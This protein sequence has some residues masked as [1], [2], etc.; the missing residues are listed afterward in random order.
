MSYFFSPSSGLPVFKFLSV[1]SPEHAHAD[2]LKASLEDSF[3]RI[4]ITPLHTRLASLNID[5]A[6]INTGIHSGLG[7]K[8]KESAPWISLVHCFNHRLEL[9]VKDTLNKTFF[10]DI[11]TMLL[12]LYYLYSKSPKRFRELNSFSEMYENTTPKP[13]KS[14]GTRW[15]Y[16]KF[17][18]MKIVLRNYGV[19]MQHVESLAQT[20]SQPLKRAELESYAKKWMNAKY[21][22]HLAIY[23]DVL[24]PLKVLSL[25]F[26]K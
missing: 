5:G 2:G 10:K 18:S 16:H 17:T 1:E 22:I 26:Q 12:K 23:L 11:D 9:A 20:D 21:P 4:G 8:V 15:I 14:Y 25:G 13:Y 7:V 19:F 24:T 6:A 3:H